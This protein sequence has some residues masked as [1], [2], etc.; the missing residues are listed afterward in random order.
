MTAAR[1]A[2]GIPPSRAFAVAPGPYPFSPRVPGPGATPI[3]KLD[4]AVADVRANAAS[5]SRT[6]VRAKW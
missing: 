1:P 5:W 3:A 2:P 6:R 4:S